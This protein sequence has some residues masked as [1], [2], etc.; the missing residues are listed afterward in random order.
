[1]SQEVSHIRPGGSETR[2]AIAALVV[3]AGQG[4]RAGQPLPKQFARW[5]GKPV[6]RHSVAAFAAAGCNPILVMI[7]EGAEAAAQEALAGIEGVRL[8]TGGATRQQSVAQG[9]EVLAGFAPGAVLI[10]DA[11]RP[12]VPGHVLERLLEALQ[13][14][15]GAIPVLPVVDSLTH[16]GPDDLMGSPAAREKLRRVQ[17]P[18]A[19]RFD[20]ILAAHRAWQGTLDAGDDA[21]VASASGME[22]ALV[23][24]D[25]TL[26]KLTYASDFAASLPLVRV[27][28]G[29]DVHRLEEGE[30]LWLCGI[31]IEHTH[32]LS[33]HSDAD[34]AIHALVDAM[35]GAIGAGDIGQHFPPS[36][37]RWKGAASDRFL[38]HAGSLVA[39][40]GYALGNADVTIICEAPKIGPHREAMRARL[41]EILGVDITSISVK[42]TTTEKLGFTGRR[43]GIA[44]QAAVSLTRV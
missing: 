23:E 33:G 38:A 25:E 10:H 22:I 8:A 9:L 26:H 14:R 13:R 34:V 40:A 20:A 21:Q 15:S 3:A 28:T 12:I 7:P 6:V 24:G 29:Y 11:A 37:A 43:E 31:R 35:L 4:L 16:A 1:M 17:T 42:A 32:G 2:G 27:G 41:A 19:F 44:A 18:Q 36:E 30:E 39:E 5:R